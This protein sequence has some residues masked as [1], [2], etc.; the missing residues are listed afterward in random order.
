MSSDTSTNPFRNRGLLLVRRYIAHRNSL[1]LAE[2]VVA[3][4]VAL[5]ELAEQL[6]SHRRTARERV[7]A[8]RT[9]H[10]ELRRQVRLEKVRQDTLSQLR[11]ERTKRIDDQEGRLR[12]L[13]KPINEAVKAAKSYVEAT[14]PFKREERLR[15]LKQIEADLSVT[16]PDP[17]QAL[18]K[19]WQ[20]IEDEE[21]MAREIALGQQAMDLNGIT[22]LVDV[23][24]IGLALM[25]YRL[26]SG[27]VGWVRSMNGSWHFEQLEDPEAELTVLDL[28]DDLE[29]IVCLALS[30]YSFQLSCHHP[31]LRMLNEHATCGTM[32]SKV[33]HRDGALGLCIF[34]RTLR[35]AA[36]TGR[37][38]R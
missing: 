14:L 28:F 26:P 2:Q 16:H 17:S 20:F 7:S 33:L 15:Y 13:L 11:S 30:D 36:C 38:H 37:N 10:S 22:R 9:E 29:K 25:Y 27:G 1:P 21:A 4:R 5:D 3:T 24:R 34:D 18:T 23:A 31:P 19:L 6:E 8:L 35:I 12:T 32:H